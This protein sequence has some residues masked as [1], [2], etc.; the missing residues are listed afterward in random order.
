M[1]FWGTN[2]TAYA[3]FGTTTR[4][5]ETSGPPTV[6]TGIQSR[7]YPHHDSDWVVPNIF[8]G[9][10][11]MNTQS[12]SQ[13]MLEK[14]DWWITCLEQ[15]GIYVW[16]DLHV[17]RQ[18]KPADGIDGFSEI[19]KGKPIADLKGYNYVNTSISARCSASMKNMLVIATG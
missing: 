16:L 3:L 4:K 10:T 14:L 18:L 8:G 13:A 1:R 11:A 2:L 7:A 15:E 9:K 12:L 5:R 17:G 6:G 19:S